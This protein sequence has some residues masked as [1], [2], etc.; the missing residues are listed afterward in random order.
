MRKRSV[1]IQKNKPY[2]KNRSFAFRP[3][4]VRDSVQRN[5]ITEHYKRINNKHYSCLHERKQA[6]VFIMDLLLMPRYS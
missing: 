5:K 2:S 4:N 3:I 6:K 1:K